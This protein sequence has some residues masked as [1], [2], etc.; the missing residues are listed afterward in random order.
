[1]F[2]VEG[3]KKKF[4]SRIIDKGI[5]FVELKDVWLSFMLLTLLFKI[6]CSDV[7]LKDIF[8]SALL[9]LKMN[10]ASI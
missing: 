10:D 7:T 1:M 5:L 9:K 3:M 2:K 8:D 6:F 4:V